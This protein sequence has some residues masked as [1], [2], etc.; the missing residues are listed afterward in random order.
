MNAGAVQALLVMVRL[1]IFLL[2]ASFV[3]FAAPPEG[4]VTFGAQIE[5]LLKKRCHGCHGAKLQMGGLRLD[6]GEDALRGGYSGPV[7][8]PGLSKES[9]LIDLVSGAKP[10]QF[11]PPSGPRLSPEE[12]AM[13]R[14]WIDRGAEWPASANWAAT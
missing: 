1:F 5:P 6:N 11:M 13:L 4:E 2:T 9:K 8:K 10:G 7:I 3:A 14:T 12:V